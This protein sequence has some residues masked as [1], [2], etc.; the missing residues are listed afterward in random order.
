MSSD[1]P[2]PRGA[3]PSPD[4]SE[5]DAWLREALRHAPD[6]G[7]APPVSLRDAILAEAR[8]ATRSVAAPRAAP[9]PS[10]LDRLLEFWSWLARPQVAAGF[11][12]VMAATLVGM[13]WWDRPMD[14]AMAPPPSSAPVAAT[15]AE[16]QEQAPAASPRA[17]QELATPATL[18]PAA[19]SAPALRD[20]STA[21][22]AK[23]AP[24]P[25]PAAKAP[26]PADALRDERKDR[27]SDKLDAPEPNAAAPAT[28]PAP[29][30]PSPFPARAPVDDD[31]ATR[32]P[33]PVLSQATR[34]SAPAPTAGPRAEPFALA[35]KAEQAEKEGAT[36]QS[37]APA[38]APTREAAPNESPGRSSLDTAEA[39]AS[40]RLSAQN[41]ADAAPR[42]RAATGASAG[43]V[44]PIAPLLAA[45]AGEGPRWSRPLGRGESV[46]IDAPVQAWLA[47]VQAAAMRWDPVADP[48]ARRDAATQSPA[49]AGT[50]LLDREGRPGALVKIEDSGVFFDLRSGTSW[51]APLAPEVVARLRATL[52]AAVR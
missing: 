4:G 13:L 43:A 47:Q 32:R 51:F 52:P 26:L 30:A 45:L 50:L 35:K 28:A 31:T 11:A 14:E 49:A 44:R 29:V 21:P 12:S 18:A 48:A 33:A 16:A 41:Q 25:V 15:V 5:H 24:P 22:S 42:Q 38:A 23:S 7:A 2:T 3:K 27:R 10:L 36:P 6:A 20:K 1:D 17:Q 40:G 19:V 34:A 9:T 39:G 8:A 37:R 46:A